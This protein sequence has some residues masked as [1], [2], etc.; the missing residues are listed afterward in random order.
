MDPWSDQDLELD[1]LA[2]ERERKRR[3]ASRGPS[4]I[5]LPK[6]ARLPHRDEMARTIATMRELAEF[7]GE[8]RAGLEI[9]QARLAARAGVSRQWLVALEQGRP[10]L[11]AGKVL[12]TLEALGFE[13]T[14]TPYLP[15]PPWMLREMVDAEARRRAV[16]AEARRRRQGKRARAKLSKLAENV[17]GEGLDLG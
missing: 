17:P 2:A 4:R 3:Q 14:L 11:E 8:L 15:P 5:V 12:R 9:P 1:R 13:V 10:T 6:K 7:V 16:A